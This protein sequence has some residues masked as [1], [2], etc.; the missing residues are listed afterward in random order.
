MRKRLDLGA[1]QMRAALFALSV[2]VAIP[3]GIVLAAP[4]GSATKPG[5][6]WAMTGR[7]AGEDRFSPLADINETNVGQLSLAWT[8]KVDPDRGMEATPIVIDGVMYESG[9]FSIV[10]ALDAATGRELWRYDPEVDRGMSNS[11]CCDVVNRGVAVSNGRV[12]VGTLDG[13]LV[14]IDA[15]TGALVWSVDTSIDVRRNYTITGA[16]RVVRGKVVIG[17][18]GAEY[19]VRGYV[20]AYDEATGKQAWRFFTVPGRPDTPDADTPAMKLARKTWYGNAYWEQGGGGTAWDSMAYDPALNMLYI[21]VGNGALWSRKLRSE[22]KGDNLFLSSIVAL[23][24]DTGDY[25]WHYQTT[26]GD[27]W[28]FT[29]TQHMILADLTIAGRARKVIMQA[30]KN[31]FFY[32]ID[33]QTGELISANNYVPVNWAKGIDL[34]TG[35]PI[36][37]DEVARYEDGKLKQVMPSMLGGHN[38]HPMSY[39][40]QTGLVYIPGELNAAFYKAL[41]SSPMPTQKGIMNFGAWYWMAPAP[42][43]GNP[44]PTDADLPDFTKAADRARVGADWTGRLIA[45][46]PVQQRSVWTQDY[47]RIFNGGTLST[48]GNLVFQG[49]ADGRFVAYRATDGK[50]LWQATTNTGVMGGPVSYRVGGQQYIAISA[51]W[52]G[53]YG[54]SLGIISKSPGVHPDSRVLVYKIGGTATLHP[55]KP[56]VTGPSILPWKGDE[57]SLASGKLN[58]AIH[59]SVC[60]GIDAI[61]G[62]GVPDLRYMS[63]DTFERIPEIV[64]G[65]LAPAGMPDFSRKLSSVQ[66]EEIRQYIAKR[67]KDL[68][69]E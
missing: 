61:G 21:G 48:A 8:Y 12:F 26:P 52:G 15:K 64:G 3:T 68:R 2:A 7:D 29:A 66:V 9:P 34:K 51:G 19:G 60:H 54:L 1:A 16:P 53:S 67:N 11:G 5:D 18:G 57:T 25:I 42:K 62:S 27:E 33:R 38:W 30:P 47:S 49:T 41:D 37:N 69:E 31:G 63:L 10:Y 23:N 43:P 55:P 36:F 45:W 46:D 58:F 32:V 22:G 65:A 35:R 59:C 50:L 39:N 14:A 13:R 6:D 17:N 40:P 4:D 44:P 24:P 56:E 20:T 28:D